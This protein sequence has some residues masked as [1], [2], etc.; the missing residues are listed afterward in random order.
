MRGLS[1]R[2]KI[3]REM[4]RIFVL[5]LLE[6]GVRWGVITRNNLDD[7][8]LTEPERE[9]ILREYASH[10]RTDRRVKHTPARILESN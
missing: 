8:L 2:V 10:A 4:H 6:S 5:R 1:L 9:T 3:T 7:P